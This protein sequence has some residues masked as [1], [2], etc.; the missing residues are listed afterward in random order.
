MA[1]T[2]TPRLDTKC[3]VLLV[4]SQFFVAGRKTVADFT[5]D[6]VSKGL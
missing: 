1:E 5:A 2:N 4:R 3:R 6:P